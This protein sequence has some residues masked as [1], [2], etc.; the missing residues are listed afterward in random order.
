LAWVGLCPAAPVIA[1]Y[2][3]YMIEKR[4]SRTRR[5]SAGGDRRRRRPES[6]NNAACQSAFI[7][8]FVL[9]SFAPPTAILLGA[10][11]PRRHSGPMMISEHP[12]LFWGVIASMYIGNFI[13]LLSTFPSFRCLR[14][15]CGSRSEFCCRWSSSSASRG[16][17]R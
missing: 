1:T 2:S 15:F 13:L 10:F 9:D 16:C 14:T 17:I 7:P 4:I 12:Q 3:S 6:A 11:D 8:L 5:N